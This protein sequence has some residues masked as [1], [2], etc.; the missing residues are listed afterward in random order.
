MLDRFASWKNRESKFKLNLNSGLATSQPCYLIFLGLSFLMYEIGIIRNK[1][2][3]YLAGCGVLAVVAARPRNFPA[4]GNYVTRGRFQQPS[5]NLPSAVQRAGSG[6]GRLFL[7]SD[8][9]ELSPY[10]LL[11]AGL[12]PLHPLQSIF[13]QLLL[14]KAWAFFWPL[15]AVHV[16]D[17]GP[18]VPGAQAFI[19]PQHRVC[20]PGIAECTLAQPELSTDPQA[21][22]STHCVMK[23][24]ECPREAWLP[25]A[26]PSSVSVL[27]SRSYFQN[28]LHALSSPLLG[29][30]QSQFQPF[31]KIPA[32]L[33][34][35]NVPAPF[36]LLHGP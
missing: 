10:L 30:L 7:V 12:R 29:P 33:L 9:C 36:F 32:R 8:I 21:E 27:S 22:P 2:F 24:Q 28:H 14:N 20:A 4:H 16:P 13:S 6:T 23:S 1:T 17:S 31:L 35:L 26:V 34:V 18:Q 3:K 25:R 5:W 19:F 15:V 11:H